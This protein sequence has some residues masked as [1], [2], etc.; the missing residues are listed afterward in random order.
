M[1]L[2]HDPAIHTG[3]RLDL[4]RCRSVREALVRDG[5]YDDPLSV[6]HAGSEHQTSAQATTRW[7]I[8]PQPFL[9]SPE[10]LRFFETLGTHLLAFY[11]G[12]NRLYLDS[13]RGTQPAWVAAYFDQGKPD[14]LVAAGRLTPWEEHLPAVIRPDIIPT[15]DG[16]TRHRMV[17]TELDSVPGGIGL[18]GALGR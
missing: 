13:A 11:R 2:A 17:M 18:T 16:P 3:S 1:A 4:D 8:A 9:L 15:D 7:R 10:D 6:R 12:V 14:S 5:L